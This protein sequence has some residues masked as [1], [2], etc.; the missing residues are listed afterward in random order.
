M[1]KII[2]AAC[3]SLAAVPALAYSGI[4]LQDD[5][6]FS[7]KCGATTVKGA[8]FEHVGTYFRPSN[9]VV[10][11]GGK[12]IFSSDTNELPFAVEHMSVNCLGDE[13]NPKLVIGVNCMA[14]APVCEKT[15][16]YVIDGKTGAVLAPKDMKSEKALCGAKCADKLVGQTFGTVIEKERYR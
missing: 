14:R 2:L 6:A 4:S 15:W 10:A 7:G 12:T 11:N 13:Q 5:V 8:A 3:L 1:K 16:F 9:V